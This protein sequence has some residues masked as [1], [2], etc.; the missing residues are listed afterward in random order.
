LLGLFVAGIVMFVFGLIKS[1]EPYQHALYVA[2]HDARVQTRLGTPVKPGWM[3]QGNIRETNDAGTADLT[4]PLRGSSGEGTLHVS[5]KRSGG[6]WSYQT[7]ELR[8]EGSA[9]LDLLAPA[10]S[11]PPEK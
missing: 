1:S 7:I 2:T 6:R 8:A 4:I 5:A 9:D 11:S 3:M 10:D